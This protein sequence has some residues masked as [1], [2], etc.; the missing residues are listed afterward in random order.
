MT[1]AVNEI[2]TP[3]IVVFF[4]LIYVGCVVAVWSYIG[5]GELYEGIGHGRLSLDVPYAGPEQDITAE[6]RQLLEAIST[7]RVA[8]GHPPLDVDAD[9]A[10]LLEPSA[11][12]RRA[13]PP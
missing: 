3:E 9:L 12:R 10:E 4:V 1:I 7:L 13:D 8:A 6:A 2:D 11:G 5:A